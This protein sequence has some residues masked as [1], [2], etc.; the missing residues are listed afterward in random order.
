[1]REQVRERQ[2]RSERVEREEQVLVDVID[3]EERPKLCN[4]SLACRTVDVSEFGVKMASRLDLP[5]HTRLGL[6]LDLTTS[7]YRLEGEVRWSRTED[8]CLVGLLLDQDSP[9]FVSWK[10]MF[11]HRA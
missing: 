7:L 10:R 2:A 6:R 3:C 1:M 9:D 4:T 5:V 11:E 8:E